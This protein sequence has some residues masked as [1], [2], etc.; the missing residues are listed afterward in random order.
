MSPVDTLGSE[1]EELTVIKSPGVAE[2]PL[3]V[4]TAPSRRW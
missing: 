1:S 3:S 4:N 2:A